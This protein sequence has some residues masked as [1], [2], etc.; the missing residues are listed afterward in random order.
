MLE[1]NIDIRDITAVN[2]ILCTIPFNQ[3]LVDELGNVNLCC[4]SHIKNMSPVAGNLFSEDAKRIWNNE[5]Y[6]TFRQ[7]FTDGSLRYCNEKSC[8]ALANKQS[9]EA[10]LLLHTLEEIR[11]DEHLSK[12][13]YSSFSDSPDTFDGTLTG[14][15]TRLYLGIDPSCNLKCPSCRDALFIDKSGT[16][17]LDTLYGNLRS[18][19]PGIEFL[20]LDGSGD[21]FASKWYNKFLRDFPVSDFPNLKEIKFRSNA[22]LWNRKNWYRI[23]PTFRAK[24]IHACISI[25]AATES[26]YEVVRGD[27]F[28]TLMENMYFVRELLENGELESISIVMIYRKSNYHEIPVFIQLGKELKADTIIINPLQAWAQS[29]YSINGTFE[30]EAIHHPSHPEHHRL[31]QLIDENNIR[32]G[33]DGDTFIDFAW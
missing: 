4:G 7:S 12:S 10:R 32:Y 24:K 22:V 28:Q 13:N 26:T 8:S 11:C 19:T 30:D 25:D 3:V 27:S 15:P 6:K 23:H 17:R 21:V 5:V 16:E 1:N 29:A 9:P 14:M 31:K 18:I 33:N 20:E 2:P